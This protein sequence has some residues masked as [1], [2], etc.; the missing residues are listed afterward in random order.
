M[1]ALPKGYLSSSQ[2]TSYILCPR[3]YKYTYIDELPRLPNEN[4]IIGRGVSRGLEVY[5]L[6]KSSL[7][8]LDEIIS[9]TQDNISDYEE[10]VG[11]DI[12]ATS[13]GVAKQCIETYIKH[14][15]KNK[16]DNYI[17]VSAEEMKEVNINGIKIVYVP[18]LIKSDITTLDDVIVDYKT[19][20]RQTYTPESI[21]YDIQTSIY[22][23]A[24]GIN[25][26]EIDEM[27]KPTKKNPVKIAISESIKTQESFDDV[28][29]IIEN[30]AKAIS[31]D[32]FPR[33]DYKHWICSPKYCDYWSLCRGAKR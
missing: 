12:C 20:T 17:V 1:Y 21:K 18:D 3:K 16:L 33:C 31:S 8:N 10:Q 14:I 19:S 7:K 25:N 24:E 30:T 32:I 2:I 5:N 22:A 13:L 29:D 28:V 23:L 6:T 27:I 15:Q 26:V 4:L 11:K 9:A